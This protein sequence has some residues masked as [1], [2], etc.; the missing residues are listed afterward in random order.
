MNRHNLNS[1]LAESVS[2]VREAFASLT[3]RAKPEETAPSRA[4]DKSPSNPRAFK[5]IAKRTKRPQKYPANKKCL[6][7]C[8]SPFSEPPLPDFSTYP[9]ANLDTFKTPEKPGHGGQESSAREDEEP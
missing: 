6:A 2:I 5:S 3:D 1:M 9:L 7:F 4:E 8:Q